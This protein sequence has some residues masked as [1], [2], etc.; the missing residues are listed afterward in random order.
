[1][2]GLFNRLSCHRWSAAGSGAM[3]WGLMLCSAGAIAV[4]LDAQTSS[5]G[6]AEKHRSKRSHELVDLQCS[7]ELTRRQVTLFANG[8]VRVKQGL[9][10]DVDMK[11]GELDPVTLQGYTDRFTELDYSEV[12][13]R[14][15]LPTGGDWVESCTLDLDF[16]DNRMR[17]LSFSRFLKSR[18]PIRRRFLVSA[19]RSLIMPSSAPK[20]QKCTILLL[21]FNSS[22]TAGTTFGIAE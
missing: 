19:G 14:Q 15:V 22:R 13:R 4:P 8:T 18:S 5:S 11:L 9:H 1:M 21:S 2:M 12:E 3:S 10:D 7:N 16:P 6:V 17:S 20:S